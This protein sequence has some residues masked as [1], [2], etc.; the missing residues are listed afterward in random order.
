MGPQNPLKTCIKGLK[1]VEYRGYD[2]AGIAGFYQGR[3]RLFKK[4]GTVDSLIKHIP[5]QRLDL[6]IGH[7]RWATHGKPN[8]L[9]AHPH[10]DTSE[11]PELA[12]VHNGTIDNYIK[13][14][15][16]LQESC[17][18]EFVSDTDTE[19]IVQLI[20]Y[21]N[22]G[23]LLRAFANS[24][25]QL[26]GSFAIVAIHKDR[27]DLILA[28]AR[29]CPLA[30][31]CNAEKQEHIISSDH[32]AFFDRDLHVTFL[33]NQIAVVSQGKLELFNEHLQPVEK[34]SVAFS[35][36]DLPAPS[37]EGFE[38][39]MLKEIFEQPALIEKMLQKRLYASCP[40]PELLSC[41]ETLQSIDQIVLIGCGTSW[42]AAK[43][44]ADLFE[45]VTRIVSRAEIASEFRYRNPVFSPCTLVVA[46]SQSGETADTIAALREA[47]RRGAHTLSI[48]NINHS[49]LVREA[50]YT[51]LLE[52]GP[53]ISVC[54][55]KAFT[56]QLTLLTLFAAYLSD[57]R[58]TPYS[59]RSELL[60]DIQTVPDGLEQVLQQCDQIQELARQYAHETRF[61]FLGRGMMYPVALEAALKL[62]EISYKDAIGYPAGELKHGPM[63]LIAPTLPVVAFCA[64]RATRAKMKNNLLEVK[65]REA[66][67]LAIAS[68]DDLDISSIADD[69][70]FLPSGG[71]WSSTLLSV[72]AGGQ[73]FPYGIAR[74][75]E[76]DVDRPRHLAKCVTVE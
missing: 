33:E 44:A 54:S 23:D 38:H 29:E 18:R 58:C 48:C 17:S 20:Q 62:K 55:T 19:V 45:D 76:R 68:E 15:R 25:Q 72:V 51:L 11:E 12:L 75:D 64:N 21:N 53:E 57:L 49:S 42:H 52:A 8:D 28:A 2:S 5:L 1:D 56:L 9:N 32:N 74:C 30:I 47:K 36:L 4:Q 35:A 69:V 59:G 66:P 26:E 16:F 43:L 73:I 22:K 34:A 14:K 63:A 41:T 61:I 24:L 37:K 70:I 10:V 65:A 60:R 7:T 50:D 67:I 31:G 40:F 46:I 6:A 39:Y 27:P 13:L 3:L 71:D